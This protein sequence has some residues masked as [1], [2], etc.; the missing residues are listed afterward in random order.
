MIANEKCQLQCFDIALSCVRMQ[1]LSETQ[2]GIPSGTFDLSNYF[3]GHH[4]P[5]IQLGRLCWSKKPELASH[6]E[7]YATTDSFLF[8]AF[9]QGPLA[10]VRVVGG[11]GLKGDV[12]TSG[13]TADVLVHK[14]I[15]LNQVEKAIN[16]LLSLNWD[17]YGAMCL[18]S[19]HRIANYIFKQPLGTERELQLQKALGSFLVP[20]KSLCYETELEFGDQVNDITL[21]FFHYLLRNRSYNKAFS[22]AI[23]INDADLFLKLHDKAKVDG[24]VELAREALRKVDDINRICT[25]RSDSERK[26]NGLDNAENFGFESLSRF[27]CRFPLFQLVLLPVCG[28]F[29]RRR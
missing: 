29:R 14:Y 11:S 2:D 26:C 23:D 13:L 16:I 8:C 10:C 7:P 28:Q 24:D 20:V 21:K 19:L 5:S 3:L 15:S 6:G 25:D 4:A 27:D 9:E 17:T 12:H 18:L 1:L 22:L